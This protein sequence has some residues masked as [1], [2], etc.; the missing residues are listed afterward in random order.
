MKSS[1]QA[2]SDVYFRKQHERKLPLTAEVAAAFLVS[3]GGADLEA[4]FITPLALRQPLCSLD[5]IAWVHVD[6]LGTGS[7]T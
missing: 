4:H 6:L 2:G 3:A 5:L 1:S 7:G